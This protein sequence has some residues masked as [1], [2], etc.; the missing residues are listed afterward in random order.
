M[1]GVSSGLQLLS[2]STTREDGVASDFG[3]VSGLTLGDIVERDSRTAV[4]TFQVLTA[5]NQTIDFRAWSEN[6]GTQ[7]Q[8]VNL[9][10]R[11]S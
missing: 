5:G 3:V 7:T 11:T 8:R 9:A 2:V 1:T 10:P 6:G 4:W